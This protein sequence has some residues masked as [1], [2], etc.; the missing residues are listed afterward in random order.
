MAGLRT[1]IRKEKAVQDE[2]LILV[3]VIVLGLVLGDGG[4]EK[5]LLIGSWL[6]V[7]IAEL[8]N[9]AIEAVTDRVGTEWNELAGQA[10][11]MGSAAVFVALCLAGLVW[12]LVIFG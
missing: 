5:A 10:K 7:I 1:A 12:L 11:D 9:S 3:P 8:L 2:L 4:V 6:V